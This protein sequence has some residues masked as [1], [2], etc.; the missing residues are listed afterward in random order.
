LIFVVAEVVENLYLAIVYVAA[1][2]LDLQLVVAAVYFVV[3]LVVEGVDD[4]VAHAVVTLSIHGLSDKGVPL[5]VLVT[6]EA[7]FSLFQQ[8]GFSRGRK[9]QSLS[10]NL[11]YYGQEK[12]EG[13]L[14]T[15]H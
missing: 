7:P 15:L 12:I 8:M 11:R 1:V 5:A 14:G 4:F 6:V 13:R 9:I 3:Q 2:E 10:P